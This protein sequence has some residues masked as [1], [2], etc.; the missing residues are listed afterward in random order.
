M[1]YLVR[2]IGES[3][4]INDNIEVKV[5]EVRGRSV[6]LG[7]TFPP[8]A[9]VLRKEIHDRI[10]RENIAASK[11]DADITEDLSKVLS[12]IDVKTSANKSR[13]TLRTKK[14]TASPTES[15]E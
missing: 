6:K 14:P 9:S 11:S 1:L 13:N 5:M 3:I 2:K 7:F 12:G 15:T 4:I 10:V 8:E